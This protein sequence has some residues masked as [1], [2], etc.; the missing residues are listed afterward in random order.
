[1]DGILVCVMRRHVLAGMCVLTGRGINKI[2]R[3]ASEHVSGKVH[4]DGLKYSHGNICV[5]QRHRPA[6]LSGM[7]TKGS[8]GT[9]FKTTSGTAA[10]RARGGLRRIGATANTR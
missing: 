10:M 1:M 2:I 7:I 5:L 4:L 8:Q 3:T 9:I 6:D